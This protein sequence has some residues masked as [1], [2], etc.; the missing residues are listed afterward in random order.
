MNF[1]NARIYDSEK[2]AFFH[3][4][5]TTEKGRITSFDEKEDATD[6][7][8]M[9]VIPGLCDIH[10]HGRAG[11]D[12]A[13]A[14]D[15]ALSTM[16]KSYA[17]VGT[18]T[19]MPTLASEPYETLLDAMRRLGAHE[20]GQRECRFLGTH[21]E[22]RYLSPARRGAHKSDL[23]APP[24]ERELT[25]FLAG[26]RLPLRI[27]M[28]PELAGAVAFA[29]VAAE[30]GVI[31]A[32]AHSD[33]TFDEA[34]AATARG[35]SIFTH[36]FNAQRPFH[37][38][39]P[40]TVGAGLLS[41]AAIE[42]ICDGFHL[43]EGTVLLAHRLK[44]GNILLVTDSMEGTGC[45][46]G[47]YA[48]AGLGVTVKNGLALQEDGTIAGSTLNLFDGMKNYIRFAGA[49]LPEAI[50]AASILPAKAAKID[51]E[52]GSLSVGKYADFLVLDDELNLLSVYIG[53]EKL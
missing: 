31:L 13:H 10:T 17:A 40:G 2:K 32:V 39:D 1:R 47:T 28:A 19:V 29:K 44:N 50:D 22:G 46:D 24:D 3:G 16:A 33:A 52:I 35:F 38:R 25:A 18:T 9:R 14:D 43:H 23:L 26:S 42:L 21:L 53:G 8:G 5:L 51:R 48:I 36:H 49:T 30:N 11:F 41:S 7:G 20:Q 45:P 15:S 12:F 27:S 4:G 37:H 34:M 6:L